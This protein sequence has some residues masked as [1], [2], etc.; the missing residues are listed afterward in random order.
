[1]DKCIIIIT[2]CISVQNQII[3]QLI[4][5]YLINSWS[6]DEF[7]Q[8]IQI[9]VSVLYH[10]IILFPFDIRLD[11]MKPSLGS[12]VLWASNG[13]L[14]P[15]FVAQ[16]HH[17][18]YSQLTSCVMYAFVL[19][20]LHLLFIYRRVKDVFVDH[21]RLLTTCVYTSRGSGKAWKNLILKISSSKHT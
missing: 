14:A 6:F 9:F 21:K 12:I 17:F 10:V 11:I 8:M 1:M 4:I 16:K 18:Y 5:Y 20:P 15:S 3:K 7:S 19:M 13:I 2:L